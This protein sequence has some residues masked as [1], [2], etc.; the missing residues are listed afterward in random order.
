MG[1]EL[2][3]Y[4]PPEANEEAGEVG[5][6]PNEQVEVGMEWTQELVGESIGRFF[7]KWK[8][9][10][11]R[12]R[13]LERLAEAKRVLEVKEQQRLDEQLAREQAEQ[14]F[15]DLS[16]YER[17]ALEWQ[18]VRT[19]ELLIESEAGRA[20][21]DLFMIWVQDL[22]AD[23]PDEDDELPSVKALREE[24]ERR[25]QS[26][27]PETIE[28]GVRVAQRQEQGG[29]EFTKGT[30]GH[31]A[32][33]LSTMAM[34]KADESPEAQREFLR[35]TALDLIRSYGT[36]LIPLLREDLGSALT[37]EDLKEFN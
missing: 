34:G 16:G 17:E 13:I 5:G 8:A 22:P 12:V 37:D 6:V 33:F 9:L 3:G 36:D 11:L 31:I 28:F 2:G 27:I 10:E 23:D 29:V 14:G 35:Q 30:Y 18:T 21:V 4:R 7:D 15:K 32:T 26:A 24:E 25:F 20:G 1:E 19:L